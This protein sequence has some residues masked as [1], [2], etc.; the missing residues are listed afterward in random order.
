MGQKRAVWGLM[1]EDPF[2]KMHVLRAL[3]RWA[4]IG[5]GVNRATAAAVGGVEL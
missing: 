2:V 1:L 4:Q 5:A 3:Y